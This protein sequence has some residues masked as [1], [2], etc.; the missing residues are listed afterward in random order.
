MKTFLFNITEKMYEDIF[1][2]RIPDFFFEGLR[3]IG[4]NNFHIELDTVSRIEKY[5]GIKR[6]GKIIKQR[7]RKIYHNE[8]EVMDLLEKYG[9]AYQE[10]ED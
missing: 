6:D 2:K 4:G 8:A 3:Y 5:G 7:E 9:C 10:Q 1:E